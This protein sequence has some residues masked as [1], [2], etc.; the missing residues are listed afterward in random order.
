MCLCALQRVAHFCNLFQ[1]G[2]SG[3]RLLQQRPLLIHH[4]ANKASNSRTACCY[5]QPP[6]VLSQRHNLAAWPQLCCSNIQAAADLLDVGGMIEDLRLSPLRKRRPTSVMTI[7]FALIAIQGLLYHGEMH[8]I[9]DLRYLGN[10]S[11]RD[12]VTVIPLKDVCFK[13]WRKQNWSAPK[14]PYSKHVHDLCL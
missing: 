5:C 11:V 4:T 3:A 13:V 8:K 1:H 2:S 7:S 14:S 10:F 9:L 12:M 6:A